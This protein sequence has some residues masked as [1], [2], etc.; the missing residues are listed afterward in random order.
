MNELTENQRKVLIENDNISYMVDGS[1]ANISLAKRRKYFN[2]LSSCP[3]VVD[4]GEIV[5]ISLDEDTETKNVYFE[6]YV[7]WYDKYGGFFIKGSID[8]IMN[9]IVADVYW[10]NTDKYETFRIGVDSF[11][12]KKMK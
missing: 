7:A 10:D 2:W 9:T 6:G 3:F 5:K 8:L 1:T 12:R 4:N 11:E